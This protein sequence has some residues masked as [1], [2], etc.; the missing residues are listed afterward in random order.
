MACA[1]WKMWSAFWANSNLLLNR[2]VGIAT[3]VR[4][5]NSTVRP[6]FFW[7]LQGLPLTNSMLRDADYACHDM[8]SRM[9]RKARFRGELW[10]E[11]FRR[12]RRDAR[13]LHL[14]LG[15]VPWSKLL[16]KLKLTWAGHVARMADSR[17]AF[18]L[19]RWRNLEWWRQQQV[20][21]ALGARNLRHPAVFGRPR[22]WETALEQF[23]LWSEDFL[24]SPLTW[25]QLALDRELWFACIVEYLDLPDA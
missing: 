14:D 3:R 7:G 9:H 15:F 1:S 11:W 10:M 2:R 22:R 21:I 18:V 4:V 16:R 25:S 17:W 5:F 20:L 12:V 13:Q 23:Q 24:R 19:T 8:I 6:V